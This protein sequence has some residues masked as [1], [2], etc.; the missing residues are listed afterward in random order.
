[1]NSNLA[2]CQSRR[3]KSLAVGYFLSKER[4]LLMGNDSLF[5]SNYIYLKS[6]STIVIERES[7]QGHVII[8][9]AADIYQWFSLH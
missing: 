1:M 6:E 7:R 3:Q 5:P 9:T 8:T 4:T 2:I